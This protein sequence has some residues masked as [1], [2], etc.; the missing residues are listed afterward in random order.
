M[1]YSTLASPSLVLCTI[2]E[3]TV[4]L[5]IPIIICLWNHTVL[6]ISIIVSLHLFMNLFYFLIYHRAFVLATYS[7]SGIK[8]KYLNLSYDDIRY[9][10]IIDVELCKYSLIPT[11]HIE[12]ICLSTTKRE[13]SFWTYPKNECI[14]L[15]HTPKVLR[16]LKECAGGKEREWLTYLI[17]STEDDSLA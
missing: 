13:S 12:M 7:Q 6:S 3:P 8:N 5:T 15:P 14:L 11:I 4:V 10:T 1:K 16:R 2:F 9:A 17:R